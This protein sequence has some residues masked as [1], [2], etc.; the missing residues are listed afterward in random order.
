MSVTN[1]KARI[2]CEACLDVIKSDAKHPV[3][4]ILQEIFEKNTNCEVNKS[5]KLL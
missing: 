4:R 5:L 2:R 1:I 3:T